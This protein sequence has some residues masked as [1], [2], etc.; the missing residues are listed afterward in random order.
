MKFNSS[1]STSTSA[2]RQIRSALFTILFHVCLCVIVLS[3]RS[4]SD[5]NK[6]ATYL[7]SPRWGS[8]RHSHRPL[9]GW[10]GDTPSLFPSPSTPS[11]SRS[12][13]RVRLNW[14]LATL[15]TRLQSLTKSSLPPTFAHGLRVCYAILISL[16]HGHRDMKYSHSRNIHF[17]T[18]HHQPFFFKKNIHSSKTTHPFCA[19]NTYLHRRLAITVSNGT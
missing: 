7:P 4:D 15:L 8:L 1:L 17:K 11:A 19:K 14:E 16:H 5:Y 18:T 13:L 12:H 9:V 10:G 6:E 3:L 2:D